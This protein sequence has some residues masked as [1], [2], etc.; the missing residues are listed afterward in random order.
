M[1]RVFEV[2]WW[3]KHPSGFSFGLLWLRKL[4]KEMEN[5]LEKALGIN[6]NFIYVNNVMS[7]VINLHRKCVLFSMVCGFVGV[8]EHRGWCSPKREGSVTTL[9]KIP[10]NKV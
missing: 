5:D 10:C 8:I 6:W 1:G 7:C 4:E 2:E 3:E 9:V